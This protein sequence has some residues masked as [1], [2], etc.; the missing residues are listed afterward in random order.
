MLVG[1]EGDGFRSGPAQGA[2]SKVGG[3][4]AKAEK[5]KYV[6]IISSDLFSAS[7][8]LSEMWWFQQGLSFLPSALVI[9]TAAAFIFSYITAIILHHVDPALPYI[10]SVK[11]ILQV[12]SH[13]YFNIEAKRQ[14]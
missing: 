11:C 5:M 2:K 14:R 4:D 6:W 9:W 3:A 7:E 13:S 1:G 8:D 10:R 12:I